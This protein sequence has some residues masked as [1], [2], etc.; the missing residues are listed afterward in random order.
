MA[1]KKSAKVKMQ[2]ADSE[3]IKME[4][5]E[6]PSPK[7]EKNKRKH[8]EVEPSAEAD[9]GSNDEYGGSKFHLNSIHFNFCCSSDSLD[10]SDAEAIFGESSEQKKTFGG[11]V[12]TEFNARDFR[13][14]LFSREAGTGKKSDSHL[15]L[16]DKMVSFQN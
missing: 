4:V 11:V 12:R 3:L 2:D 5:E 10:D 9:D 15:K 14:K 6:K 1:K 16:L 8:E 7:K 13:Q